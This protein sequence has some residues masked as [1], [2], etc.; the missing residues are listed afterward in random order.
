MLSF[1]PE[2]FFEEIIFREAS[3]HGNDPWIAGHVCEDAL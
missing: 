1:T 3:V 2:L